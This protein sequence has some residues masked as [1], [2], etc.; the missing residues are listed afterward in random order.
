MIDVLISCIIP[1]YALIFYTRL[2]SIENTGA[3]WMFAHIVSLAWLQI[4]AQIFLFL[5]IA[6]PFCFALWFIGGLFFVDFRNLSLAALRPI[7]F[8]YPLLIG[9]FALAIIPPW[10]RDSLTYHLALPQLFAQKGAYTAGDEIIFGYFPLG[11]HSILTYIFAYDAQPL[12][13]PRLVSVWLSGAL[14]MGGYGLTQHYNTTKGWSLVCALTILLVPTQIEFGTSAYVQ[15]WLSLI[16]MGAVFSLLWKDVRWLGLCVGLAISAKYSGLFLALLCLILSLSA[17][18]KKVIHFLSITILVG[19]PFYLRNIYLKGNPLFPLAYDIFGGSGWD[20]QRAYIYAETLKNYGMGE[21]LL[22]YILLIPRIFF[23]QDMVHY[24]Q[25]S[26][27]PVIGFL[28]FLSWRK[29]DSSFLF[30]IG[31]LG[32]WSL[33][34]Q[35]IRFLMP[36]VPIM[37]VLGISS[38][39]RSSLWRYTLVVGGSIIWGSA[40]LPLL[41]KHLTPQAKP[42]YDAPFLF[43]WKRQHTSSYLLGEMTDKELLGKMHKEIMPIYDY[44]RHTPKNKVWLVYTRAYVY[45]LNAPFRLDNIVED[46]RFAKQLR[47]HSADEWKYFLQEEGITHIIIN[48]RFFSSTEFQKLL[49]E[50][51][52]YPQISTQKTVL[53]EVSSSLTNPQKP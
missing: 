35:Q 25:G 43:L 13:N 9:Y 17:G 7:L 29:R 48:H 24:F 34:V 37:I 53:Y 44:L 15:V 19:A 51:V 33:Q 41:A 18:K 46:F 39:Q 3:R 50:K 26:L 42:L 12:F 8:I 23:T 40:Y 28:F 32:L 16:A 6:Q 47:T 1:I 2:S 11:W 21:S 52:L 27:G 49:D 38:I 10:Y 31:F 22:D 20:T 14:A 36:V 30:M 45:Y 4:G 5:G